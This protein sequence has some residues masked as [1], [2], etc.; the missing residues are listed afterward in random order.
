M[1]RIGG[2]SNTGEGGEDTD[3]YTRDANG[4]LRRSAIKQVAS[5]RF[6]VTSEYLVNSDEIQIKIAQGA[7]PGEGGQLPGRKVYPWIAKVRLSTPGV[8]LIS[9]PPHHDIYSIEDL[10][11]LIYDLKNANKHA[12]I[13]VKLVSEV[14]V[15]T[16]AAG[17]AKGHADVILISG[18]SGGTGASPQSSIQH[19][20][21]PWE[22]GIAETHQTLLLNN[23]RSRVILETDGQLKTGRDV[24]IA[25]LLG[26]EEYGFSTSP[27]IVL[28]C[29]MM[30]VC[31]LDTCPVGVATQNPELRKKFMGDPS[32][33]VTY[34]RF[35]AQE[36]REIMASLGFR[37]VNEMV[38]QMD[39]LTTKGAIDHWK[40][41]TLLRSTKREGAVVLMG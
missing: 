21:L 14:G 22:L 11:E 18:T 28:G 41:I 20:G 8:G 24:A 27:L 23:L 25:A 38:G 10:A 9:P 29:I 34:L 33:V 2:K 13:N 7:K 12:R 1:N 3:R 26:A 30:R 35:V 6:G 40:A 32:D 4:D 39:R 31:H 16:I 15:G 17:V 5:G 36:L 19:A 37:T